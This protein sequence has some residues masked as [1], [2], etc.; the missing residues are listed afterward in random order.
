MGENGEKLSNPFV[1]CLNLVNYKV[2]T[3]KIYSPILLG[4]AI[5]VE[6]IDEDERGEKGGVLYLIYVVHYI[7]CTAIFITL[8]KDCF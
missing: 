4:L 2:C 3:P 6:N 7:F 5:D 1:L 8:A